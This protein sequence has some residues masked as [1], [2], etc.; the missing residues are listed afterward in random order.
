MG[1]I[2]NNTLRDLH[3][4]LNYD[5]EVEVVT[6]VTTYGLRI[7]R[8]SASFLLI[9]ACRDLFPE[10]TLMIKH[11]LS[12]GLFCQFL[13]EDSTDTEIEQISQRMKELV[14]LD[15]PI[16]RILVENEAA[17]RVFAQQGQEDKVKLL[18]YRDKEATH[19]YE[20]DGFKEYSYGYMVE[21]TGKLDKFRLLYHP[22]GMIL[23]TPEVDDLDLQQPYREQK[24]LA[25]V[26]QE[27]KDWA[28]ML[29]IPH[30]AAL[31]EAILRGE[32]DD[33]MRVNE[34]LHE[35]KIAHIADIIY[36]NPGIR[37]VS[38]AGPS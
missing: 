6:A 10:R 33:I 37:L 1:G 32:I 8:R 36:H 38:I 31:N 28:E 24:K 19:V 4:A 20:L 3:Y 27:S 5:S 22:P 15:L 12:N 16:K 13:N 21:R 18:R 7:Y 23:R 25:I 29:N 34:A 11:T 17:R 30:V 9:K 26:H 35:K 14:E 2:I